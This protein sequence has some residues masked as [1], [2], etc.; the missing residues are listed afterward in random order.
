MI[1]K[2]SVCFKKVLTRETMEGPLR[3][4]SLHNE[5]CLPFAY[6]IILYDAVFCI[7]PWMPFMI[8]FLIRPTEEQFSLLCVEERLVACPP[9][10]HCLHS[11]TV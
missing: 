6:T 4:V 3:E 2:S 10:Q 7:R 9:L 5:L 11:K 8:R 1:I